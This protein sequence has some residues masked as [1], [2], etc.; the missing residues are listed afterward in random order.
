MLRNVVLHGN[1]YAEQ[2]AS[3]SAGPVFVC[4]ALRE[5]TPVGYKL[6][7]AERV[8]VSSLSE[9]VESLEVF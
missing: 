1:N 3:Q 5:E 2:L 9:Y 8:C 4:A 6:V 7:V